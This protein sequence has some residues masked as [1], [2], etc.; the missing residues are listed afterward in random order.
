MSTS[1][2]EP[3]PHIHENESTPIAPGADDV[4]NA[5]RNLLADEYPDLATNHGD[6][7][8]REPYLE[9]RTKT[10]VRYFKFMFQTWSGV[11]S[12]F[13]R[14]LSFEISTGL[15]FTLKPLT[16]IYTHV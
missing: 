8:N 12:S 6:Q 5:I 9:L 11:A 10:V 4:H 1:T 14:M 2:A 16:L 15:L 13:V 3:Q 7:V